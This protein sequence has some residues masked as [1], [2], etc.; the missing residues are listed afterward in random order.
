MSR[1][2]PGNY[3]NHEN[4]LFVTDR[5]NNEAGKAMTKFYLLFNAVLYAAFALWCTVKWGQTSQASGYL[6]L[7]NAGRSEYLV[8]YGGLQFG[9]AAFYACTALNPQYQAIGI[10]FSL[11]IYAAI[12]LYRLTSLWLFWPVGHVTLFLAGME[13]LLL[14]GAIVIFTRIHLN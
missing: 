2:D 3:C 7:S 14:V 1:T 6:S 10:V 13:T 8:I 9:I 11:C 5:V 12:V 4:Y